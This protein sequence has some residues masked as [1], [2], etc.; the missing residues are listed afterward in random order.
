MPARK[1]LDA[2]ALRLRR[3]LNHPGALSNHGDLHAGP[4]ECSPRHH[5]SC[6]NSGMIGKLVRT[7]A[8]AL[9]AAGLY[10][11]TPQYVGS[12]KCQRVTPRST[13]GGARRAWRTWCGTRASTRKRSSRICR[14]PDPLVT[15]KKDDIAFIYGSKWKQ[16]YF[17]KVGD[18]YFP[19]PAQWDVTHKIW[20]PY[21]V[22]T[23]RTGGCRTIQPT[24]CSGPPGPLCDGCH[25]VNYNV[26]TKTVDGVERGLREM[27]R[28]RQRARRPSRRGQH[29]QSG[30]ARLRQRQRRLHPVPFAGPAAKAIRSRDKY[31]DWPVGFE[32]GQEPAATSGSWR[33]TSSARRRSRILPTAR[34][35]KTACRATTSSERDVHAAA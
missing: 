3:T 33:I 1:R 10:A 22:A 5:I 15:F 9:L 19:L 21:F 25:S 11:Q 14:K 24:T 2:L 26:Q 4:T 13:T 16:R 23:A 7:A 27:S 35:T 34:P 30:A 20:R 28:T 12:A 18:D 32:H 8:G 6:H 31:Y 29:R 17:T